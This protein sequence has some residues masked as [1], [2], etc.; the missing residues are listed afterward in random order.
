MP[1]AMSSK[2]R[3]T[4]RFAAAATPKKNHSAMAPTAKPDSKPNNSLWA[5]SAER[6]EPTQQI[7]DSYDVA[8]IGGGF[9]GLWSAYHLINLNSKLKI[10]VF[11]AK[12]FG[13]GASGR[14][15][16]WA[17]SDYPV[18]RSTLIKRHGLDQANAL[19]D[20]LITS[21]NEIGDFS[22]SF[23]PKSNFTKSG[24]VMFARNAAQETR[25]R[26]AADEFHIW[27]TADELSK[28]I[29]VS[30]ARGGLFNPE[31]ATVNPI[32]L[33]NGLFEYLKLRQVDLF[34]HCFATPIQQG[35]LVN[36]QRVKTQVV[37]QA[38]EVYGAARRE[39]IPLYSQMVATEPL[40]QGFWDEV[41]V[42]ERFTFAEGSHLINYAQR[43]SDDRLAIG[44][45]GATYPF[46][47]RLEESKEYTVL[48]HENI[49]KLAKKWFPQLKDVSFTH[50]WGGAVAITRDWEPYIQFD[51]STGFGRLGG[52][53]GDGVT[54]SYLAAKIISNLVVGN[55][56]ELTGLHF[57]NRRIR[58]WEPEPLRYL[59]V[60]SLVKL[61]GVA[62]REEALTNRAS[63]VSKLIAPLILR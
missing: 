26:A 55:S 43:T 14:N 15:G 38:T 56:N 6:F 44:G 50:A 41:G 2:P 5:D 3:K 4:S 57:V 52:Y 25:L 48:V 61:S 45:R 7:A 11:E 10:A 24:T 60:N 1:M 62:D 49:R 59:A 22:Q 8:I 13:F 9:S 29:R 34:E 12:T 63:V 31:C 16:G 17:S 58:S 33:L 18:S 30:D 23:A 37:I 53:A 54:M 40:S 21:I 35:V 28:L 46:K 32:G 47:S 42:A 36:S 19:F 20:S 39:F 51:P 27:K